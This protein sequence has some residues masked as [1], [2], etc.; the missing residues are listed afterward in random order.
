[1]KQDDVFRGEFA[2]EDA[3]NKFSE[4]KIK[5]FVE[6]VCEKTSVAIPVEARPLFAHVRLAVEFETFFDRKTELSDFH[7]ICVAYA[8]GEET[9]LRLCASL[10]AEKSNPLGKF[11][12]SMLKIPFSPNPLASN[13]VP[14]CNANDSLHGMEHC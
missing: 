11:C 1:M 2:V 8:K 7:G 12:A 4:A 9:V 3:A 13:Y 10:A 6:F 5:G 14:S